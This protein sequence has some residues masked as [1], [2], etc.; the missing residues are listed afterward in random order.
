MVFSGVR[1]PKNLLGQCFSLPETNSKFAPENG[2]L[3][4]DCFLLGMPIFRC[5]LLV[6]GRIT[7]ETF[8]D[9]IFSRENKVQTFISGSIG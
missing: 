7:F 5:E 2:W 9:Y 3:E 4:D 1:N 8:G 6:S